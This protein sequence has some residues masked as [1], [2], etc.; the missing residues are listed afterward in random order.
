MNRRG[1]LTAM[2][3]AGAAPAIVKAANIMPIFTRR[4]DLGLLVPQLGPYDVAVPVY[5]NR[6]LTIEEITREALRVIHQNMTFISSTNRIY[7]K[8]FSI[9]DTIKIRRPL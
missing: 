4:D 8:Q 7:D 5:G 2:L 6:L 9:G 3:A 1:F